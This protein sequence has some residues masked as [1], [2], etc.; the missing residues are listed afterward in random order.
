MGTLSLLVGLVLVKGDGSM[1]PL[2]RRVFDQIPKTINGALSG[3]KLE[4]QVTIY[5][6]CPAC[7]FT[8]RPRLDPKS[9]YPFYPDQCSNTPVPGGD[10]CNEPLLT[11]GDGDDSKPNRPIKPF[12]YHH[13]ADYLA[14]LLSQH[15]NVMDKSTDDCLGSLN[16]P[17]PICARDF[18]DAEFIRTFRGPATTKP[19]VDRPNGEGRYLFALNVDFF[20]VEGK[21]VRGPTTSSGIIAMACLNL[22][23]EIRYLPENMYLNI[24]PGP[25]EPSLTDTNHYLRPLINDMSIAWERGIHISRTPVFPRGRDTRSAIAAVVCDLPGARKTS[26]LA[27]HNSYWYCSVCSC[28]HLSTRG[29]VNYQDWKLRNCN[30]LRAAAEAWRN[31]ATPIQQTKLF[32]ANGVRWSELWRLP[33]WDPTRQLV[34]DPMHCL[35]LRLADHHVRDLLQLTSAAAMSADRALPAFRHE[36]ELPEESDPGFKPEDR[37]EVSKIHR[38]LTTAVETE[39]MVEEQDDAEEPDDL[40]E[41]FAPLLKKLSKS[42]LVALRFVCDDLDLEV[43]PDP[44]RKNPK[45]RWVDHPDGSVC[46]QWALQRK[47]FALALVDW[48]GGVLA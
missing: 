43:Q 2:E 47:D 41:Q 7:D 44:K 9:N 28:C 19:F 10:P 22:P 5:A 34:V 4:G 3:L 23:V 39:D 25:R 6:A 26:A 17:P 29:C 32:Q 15:E 31:A 27:S 1:D 35:L 12:I 36:F 16:N 37:K 8:H 45:F 13:F 48:V 21:R 30:E 40:E 24:I 20:N 46:R 42:R 33:Y 11:R 38:L 18:F 14:G